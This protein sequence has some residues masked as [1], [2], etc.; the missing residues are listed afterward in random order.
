MN[1]KYLQPPSLI[2]NANFDMYLK[3]ARPKHCLI[4]KIF[5]ISHAYNNH[6]IQRLNAV[7][8]GQQLV[9]YCV[10]GVYFI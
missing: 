4:H 8:V 1:F 5:P 10:F 3:P 2:G 6:I 9:H 7:Q